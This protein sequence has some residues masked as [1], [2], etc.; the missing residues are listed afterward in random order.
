[1]PLKFFGLTFAATWFLWAVALMLSP[2]GDSGTATGAVAAII[3]LIGVAAPGIVALPLTYRDEGASAAAALVGRALHGRVDVRWYVFALGLMPATKL[4]VAL[5]HRLMMGEWPVFGETRWYVMA[6]AIMMSTW[7]QAGEEVGWRGYALPR[8]AGRFGLAPA[9]LVLGA[10]WAAWHLPLFFVPMA[11]T[12][13]Q[14]FPLYLLQVTALSVAMAWLYARTQGSLLLVMLLHA[15]I[16]N[17]KDIVPSAVQG[18]SDPL[19]LGASA[20]GWLTLAILW[21][22]AAV[23]LFQMRGVKELVLA[24]SAPGYN[25]RP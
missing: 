10:I 23:L 8:L 12:F 7:V 20:P 16:N 4:L 2:G 15:S 24:D 17:T 1:M 22:V 21:A 13:G 14:S 9:S 3:F 11:D 19:L 25:A 6:G 18:A 5:L